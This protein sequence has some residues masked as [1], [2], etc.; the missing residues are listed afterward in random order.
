[1]HQSTPIIYR[2]ADS[3]FRHQRLFWCALLLV[4]TLTM[5]ALY[6]R[7][8]TYHATAMTQ[9]QTENVASILNADSQQTSWT[10]PSQKNV[11]RFTELSKQDQPGGFLDTALRNAHLAVPINVDPQAD[12][13]RY[14]QLQKNLSAAAESTNQFSISLIWNNPEEC[15]S[16][17]DALQQRY[18]DE[19]GLDRS[20]VSVSSVNFLNGQIAQVDARM[21]RAELALT[22]YKATYSGQLSDSDNTYNSQLGSLQASLDDKQVTLGDNS[23]KKIA[24]QQQLAEMKPMSIA[25][26]TVS[27]QSPLEKQIADLLAKREVLLAGSPG[28]AARTPDHPDVVSL[29]QSIAAL[30]KQQK[31]KAGS[32]ENQHNT[33]TEMEDNPQYQLLQNEIADASS[34]EVSDQQQ[35]Q[36]LQHQI[37]KYRGLVDKIPAAQRELADRT[38]DYSDAQTLDQKL[39]QQRD[40]VQLQ[41]NLDRV[42]A[43]NSLL[44]IGVTYAMPTTGRTKLIAMLLGS[45]FLGALVG[46]IL[47]V[48]SEWSDHSLRHEADAERLLGV[49]VL[50]SVPESLDLWVLPGGRSGGSAARVLT[51]SDAGSER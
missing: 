21:R 24:L 19:V 20:A 25:K 34:A 12:D 17:V 23:R 46:A 45:L 7:S 38:R 31:I 13:P 51:T 3:F 1:M 10:T 39:R 22:N 40:T 50:A 14:A 41:A 27:E 49:P 47:I 26:Q 18:V 37:A 42:T 2:I 5:G 44:P 43:S 6:A 11:D 33:Q 36:N 8:K 28:M 32:P 48:L 29:D 35:M 4:S 15:K 16:I 30:E 9:V